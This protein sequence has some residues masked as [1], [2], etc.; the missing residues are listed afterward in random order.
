M[1]KYFG[2]TEVALGDYQKLVRGKKEL[3]VFGMNDVVTAMSAVSYKDGKVKVVAGE[4][5]I[6]LVKFTP[7][8]PE[9]SFSDLFY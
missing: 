1:L 6:E 3:P 4:S 8:G 9:T 5:Y 2:T 7:D